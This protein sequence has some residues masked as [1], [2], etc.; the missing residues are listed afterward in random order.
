[1][2]DEPKVKRAWRTGPK[3]KPIPLD[4]THDQVMADGERL[5]WNR[6]ALAALWGVHLSTA[7]KIMKSVGKKATITRKRRNGGISADAVRA[8]FIEAH[9]ANAKAAKILGV[10]YWQMSRLITRHN[11]REWLAEQRVKNGWPLFGVSK[12]SKFKIRSKIRGDKLRR[13]LMARIR[14]KE[15]QE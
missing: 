12:V 6:P 1:M 14:D 2:D 3:P 15:P 7:T 9:G 11:L 4:L 8:A 13:R 10:S 5:K